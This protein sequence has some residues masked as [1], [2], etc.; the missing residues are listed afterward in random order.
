MHSQQLID[1]DI[2]SFCVFPP[3]QF[4]KKSGRWPLKKAITNQHLLNIG[5]QYLTS[6]ELYIPTK[7][8]HTKSEK[9]TR[10]GAGM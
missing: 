9:D 10:L 8:P 3:P 5:V 4:K 6:P 2:D 1:I 7:W